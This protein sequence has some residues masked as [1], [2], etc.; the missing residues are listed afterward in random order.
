MIYLYAVTEPTSVVPDAPGLE[1][2]P[3][4]SLGVEELGAL[5]SEHDRKGF[6]PV[7]DALWRHDQVVEAAM[8]L[9]PVLPARFGTAFADESALKARL[10]DERPRLRRV[11]ENVRGCVELAVRVSFP[12]ES[13]PASPSGQAYLEA[14]LARHRLRQTVAER[15]LVPLAEHAVRAHTAGISSV[16]GTLT[17]SYLVREPEVERFAGQVSELARRHHELSL[18]CTGPWPPYSFVEEEQ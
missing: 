10:V 17:A 5:Y 6:D 12:E 4:Q 7:P 16:T 2:R 13:A 15:T 14:K 9:G 11:L 18:S 3:L 8:R 1:D